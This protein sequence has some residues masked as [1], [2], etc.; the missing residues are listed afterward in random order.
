MMNQNIMEVDFIKVLMKN[1]TRHLFFL[2]YR[3]QIQM[4]KFKGHIKNMHANI[5]IVFFYTTGI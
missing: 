3:I 4:N 2:R 5:E 1:K